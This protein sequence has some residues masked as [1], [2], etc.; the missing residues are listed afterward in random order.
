MSGL[1]FAPEPKTSVSS[2]IVFPHHPQVVRKR[3]C[4][5]SALRRFFFILKNDAF[6]VLD[7]KNAW[8]SFPSFQGYWLHTTA[9]PLHLRQKSTT[10]KTLLATGALR[11]V[12]PIAPEAMSDGNAIRLR[13]SSR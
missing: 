11:R 4:N 2:G 5:C 1:T 10:S 7:P 12:Q 13:S 6:A 8:V 9:T 3:R